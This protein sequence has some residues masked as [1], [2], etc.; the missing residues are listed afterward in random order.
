MS[1]KAPM[2]RTIAI[3]EQL[4]TVLASAERPLTTGEIMIG[5]AEEGRR[6][7]SSRTVQGGCA[8]GW[9]D[10]YGS[11]CSGGC[12]HPRAYPQLRAL[13]RLGV[14]SHVP[15]TDSSPC[16]HWWL[17]DST[18]DNGGVDRQ[19]L[20]LRLSEA[21]RVGLELRPCRGSGRQATSR[22]IGVRRALL[23]ALNE[24]DRP[25]S[26]DEVRQAVAGRYEYTTV[27]AQLCRLAKLGLVRHKP[28]FAHP[29]TRTALWAAVTDAESDAAINAILEISE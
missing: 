3:R 29:V 17:N 5:L 8:H 10:R 20:G 16:A 22:I 4:V 14:I 21:G 19:R 28:R 9:A 6:C 27:Y 24:A 13:E 7:D 26:T 12:W 18:A 15:R 23:A 2:A 11:T 25:L 1:P